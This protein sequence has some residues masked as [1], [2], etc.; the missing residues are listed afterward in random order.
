M[1][2]AVGPLNGFLRQIREEAFRISAKRL[3][4]RWS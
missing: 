2:G 1:T 4:F 3:V